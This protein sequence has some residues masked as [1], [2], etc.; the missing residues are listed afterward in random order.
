MNIYEK[1]LA[2]MQD[3]EYLQKDGNVSFGKTNYNYLSE[4]KITGSI[5]LALIRNRLIMYPINCEQV[6]SESTFD[7]IIMT[8]RIVDIDDP[9]SFIDVKT[10]GCGHDSGDKKSY[11]AMTGAFKYAQRQTFMIS[12][13]DDPDRDP[14]EK[15]KEKIRSEKEKS[16]K[17]LTYADICIKYSE[18]YGDACTSTLFDYCNG[19]YK[20]A[21]EIPANL[22]DGF[23]TELKKL[24]SNNSELPFEKPE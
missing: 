13:G 19:K 16:D 24:D 22:R 6:Q 12:T 21:K 17:K 4:E 15:T 1:I 10:K 2:V 23:I 18:K 8:Y 9:K 14:S 11:K 5:R 7:N 20:S 3:V